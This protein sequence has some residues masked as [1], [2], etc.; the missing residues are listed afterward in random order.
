MFKD[1]LLQTTLT[2]RYNLHSHTEFCD[3][4]AT[5][6]AFARK[7]VEY[8]FSLYGFTPHSPIPFHSPCN[9]LADKVGRYLNECDIIRERH[10][11]T[12]FL[13]GM[14][15]DYL[16]KDYGPAIPYFRDMGLDYS[17]GSVHF[18]RTQKGEWVDIDGSNEAFA[19]RL[20]N[21]FS[22]DLD[23]II[24][25]FFEQSLEM[26]SAGGFDIIGH[27]DKIADNAD[28]ISPGIEDNTRFI[29]S[30][31]NLIDEIASAGITAEINTKKYD[32]KKRFFPRTVFWKKLKQ[33]NIPIVVNSDAHVPALINAGRD[34]A[35]KI[36]KEL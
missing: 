21:Y 36:L 20:V 18:I 26:I 1:I 29:D 2:D 4:K 12:K 24:K 15:I 27:F 7:A 10:P 6:E 28:F 3:G 25:S 31:D 11:E 13:K 30:V 23:Y 33:K 8:R 9:M 14:E 17:I 16:G 32:S 19:S 35:L 22:N 5:M 34:E